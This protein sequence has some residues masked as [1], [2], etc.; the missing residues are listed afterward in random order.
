M[1]VW[2]WC[3]ACF[4]VEGAGNCA[5]VFEKAGRGIGGISQAQERACRQGASGRRTEAEHD[6]DDGV[7]REGVERGGSADSLEGI[8]GERE[9]KR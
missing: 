3:G 6:D 9:K 5:G 4:A 7:D 8:M 1:P 2:R